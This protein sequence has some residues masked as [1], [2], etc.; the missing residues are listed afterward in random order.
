[1]TD[2]RQLLTDY[3]QNGSE[4]AFRELVT[5]YLDLVYST[6]LRLVDGD[7]HR[8]RDIAQIVFVDLAAKAQNLS[9]ETMPGGWLHRHT[10]FVAANTLRSE[11]RRQARERLAVE[12]NTLTH[13]SPDD[14]S[15]LAPVLDEL[16]NTLDDSD[17]AAIL[18]RFYEQRDFRAIGETLGT[19]EDAARMRVNRALD[20]LQQSLKT[21]GIQTTAAA[22][23]V[24]I[25]A[26]AVQAA[27]AGLASTIA[28]VALAGA[29]T[30]TA[31]LT[32]AKIIAMTT[33]QK[34]AIS[35]VVI[36]L[37]GAGIFEAHQASQLREQIQTLQQQQAPLAEQ[38]QQLQ[39]NFAEATNRLADL[40]TADSQPKRN[41]NE[42][43]LLKLRGE[44]TRLRAAQ[45]TASGK[46][47]VTEPTALAQSW[48]DRV[49]SL[50]AKLA[51]KPEA[52]IPEL[53]FVTD[54]DWL[55]AARS[56]LDTEGDYRKALS[57]IRSAGENKFV[58]E[59]QPALRK[60]ME[61]H[62]GKFPA[63]LADLQ[64][65]FKS[66]VDDAILQRWAI[67]PAKEIKSLGMGGDWIIT[68]KEVVDKENDQQWGVGP[69]GYGTTGFGGSQPKADPLETLSPALNA[70][71]ASNG[72]IPTE[73]SQLL[74]YATTAEQKAQ[75]EQ[76]IQHFKVMSDS[77][78][79]DMK[80]A[81]EKFMAA[82]SNAAK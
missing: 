10:C 72:Q 82:Q 29:V 33:L 61:E 19:S 11:R 56:K 32:S 25:F 20:R 71:L 59:L 1:M 81:V 4:S 47:N 35:A 68:Q 42:T 50:K 57:R 49:N 48:L 31:T 65:Y 77:E 27:P 58:S 22:L 43:E 40:L 17:R 53:K 23:S 44:V 28:T 63:Q 78:K 80:N 26:G 13:D 12:M 39:S 36:T 3:V 74:P 30:T 62:D 55:D 2:T 69:N 41:S 52:G 79:T 34:I 76:I 18:L 60:Y 64:A 6:A 21:R 54:Q 45:Q 37:A 5:R 8:A 7:A 38:I 67:V 16:I 70:Y 14:F 73:P 66:P 9:P 51:Q 24:T 46:P 15:R 75:L